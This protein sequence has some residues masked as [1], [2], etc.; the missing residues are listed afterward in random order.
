M[1]GEGHKQ[2]EDGY[3]VL[4]MDGLY[5]PLLSLHT[6]DAK[7]LWKGSINKSKDNSLLSKNLKGRENILIRVTT[8]NY[9]PRVYGG[10]I[11]NDNKG[12]F[13]QLIIIVTQFLM[14]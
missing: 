3:N 11:N 1:P 2:V 5:R 10:N 6:I 13:G 9:D 7:N 14:P 4:G 8:I 12:S